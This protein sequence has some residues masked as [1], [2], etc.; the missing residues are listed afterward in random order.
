[1]SN[2]QKVII[3]TFKGNEL[4]VDGFSDEF[5]SNKEFPGVWGTGKKEELLDF[6]HFRLYRYNSVLDLQNY[7]RKIYS[8]IYSRSCVASYGD[9]DS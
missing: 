2:V 1:M 8:S 7:F 4:N 5:G 3:F 9:L 6:D